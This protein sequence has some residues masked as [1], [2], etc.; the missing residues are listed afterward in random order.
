M[1]KNIF[2]LSLLIILAASARFIP[3][4]YNFTPIA[5]MAL[6]GAAYFDKKYLAYIVPILTL[7]LSDFILNNTLYRAFFPDHTG[8][9]IFSKFM[10]YTYLGTG[11]MVAIGHLLL[12]KVN[13]PRILGSA[14]AAT[15]VFFLVSNF[16]SWLHTPI[17]A[18]SF[19]GLLSAY[20]AG[21]PFLNGHLLGN[22]LFSFILFGAF[23]FMTDRKLSKVLSFGS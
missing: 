12:R 21:L 17:Y 5:G 1:K 11:L 4:G 16:G 19:P 20:V 15:I 23:E 22:I 8:I 7:F 6:L 14:V 13:A 2:A 9:V 10:I 3:H 18:K